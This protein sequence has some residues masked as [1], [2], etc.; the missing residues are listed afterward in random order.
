MRNSS[1]LYQNRTACRFCIRCPRWTPG[2]FASAFTACGHKKPRELA[3]GAQHTT[4]E[5]VRF[6]AAL[7]RG[8]AAF[9]RCDFRRLPTELEGCHAGQ[10]CQL[11]Q[12]AIVCKVRQRTE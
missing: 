5:C 6:I 4:L 3:E 7:T 9:F 10:E 11:F 2:G 1:P 12:L 8:G